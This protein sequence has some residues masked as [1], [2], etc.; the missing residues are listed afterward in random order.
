VTWYGPGR[1]RRCSACSQRIL[2]TDRE[3]ECDVTGG[4]TIYFHQACY[5]AWQSARA[6]E[7]Q[8]EG[9]VQAGPQTSG[10]DEASVRRPVGP[11]R[12]C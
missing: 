1:G 10:G 12:G 8:S 2:G 3:I 4:D 5:E 7:S 9:P 11:P 6:P